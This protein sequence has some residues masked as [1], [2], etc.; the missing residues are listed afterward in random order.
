MNV[1]KMPDSLAHGHNNEDAAVKSY[2]SYM[3]NIQHPVNV[4]LSGLV[5]NPAFPHLGCSPD[6]KVADP[7]CHPHYGIV[8]VKCPYASRDLTPF[9]AAQF[10]KDDKTFPLMKD[11]GRL[12]LKADCPHMIHVQAQMAITGAKWCD[13]ILYTFKGMHVQRVFYNENFWSSDI[14]PRVE[15]FYFNHF[16]PYVLSKV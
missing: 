16:A 9:E 1:K 10:H 12:V 8:E 14:L 5:V 7:L 13:Y 6:R 3:K 2:H 15:H 11:N 4:F